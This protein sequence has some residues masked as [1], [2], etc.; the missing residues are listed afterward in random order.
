MLTPS[1]TT[2]FL[3]D[4]KRC[5]KRGKDLTKLKAIQVLLVN[6]VPLQLKHK[7][8]PLTGNWS[9]HRDCPIEPD[10]VLIYRIERPFIYF[11]RT[12]SHADLF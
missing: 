4:L 11:E 6:E 3:K 7:D 12:G 8:H 9:G 2:R 1:F 5:E 10:W